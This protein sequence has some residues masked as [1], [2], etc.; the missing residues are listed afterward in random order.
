MKKS[1]L[2]LLSLCLLVAMFAGCTAATTAAPTTAA[3]TTAAPTTAA[4]TTAAPTTAAPTT[5]A[6]AGPYD[7]TG[8]ET[9]KITFVDPMLGELT[10]D[11]FWNPETKQWQAAYDTK[12]GPSMLNGTYAEDGTFTMI[13]DS[14]DGYGGP[15]VPV[16]S[17]AFKPILKG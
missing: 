13:Y 2:I 1:L 12:Y 5:T 15:V 7:T 16:L 4:P 3:P 11:I 8:W 9:S 6:K 14:S 17:E 10:G